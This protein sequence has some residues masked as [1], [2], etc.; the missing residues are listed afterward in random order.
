MMP[1]SY[2]SVLGVRMCAIAANGYWWGSL[3]QARVQGWLHVWLDMCA[4]AGWVMGLRR[5]SHLLDDRKLHIHVSADLR[6]P[7]QGGI[8]TS[9][10]GDG[11]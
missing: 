8:K 11:G 3:R 10:L 6:P 5:V 7:R 4:P 1:V 9:G 2:G